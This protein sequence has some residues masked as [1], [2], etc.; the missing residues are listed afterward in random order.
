MIEIENIR[1]RDFFLFTG[2]WSLITF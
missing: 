2:D 1:Q